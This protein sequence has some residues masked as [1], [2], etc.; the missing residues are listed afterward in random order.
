MDIFISLEAII[1]ISTK[2]SIQMECVYERQDN[3]LQKEPDQMVNHT[4]SYSYLN[5]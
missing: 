4:K 3:F 2:I 1:S 5:F